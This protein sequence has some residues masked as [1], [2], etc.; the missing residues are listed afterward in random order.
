VSA[1]T[2]ISA[3]IAQVNDI[4]N[5]IA[6]AV[7]ER[8]AT[9]GEMIRNIAEAAKSSSEIAQNITVVAEAARGTSGGAT[10]T[11]SASIDLSRMASELH[12]LV[13]TFKYQDDASE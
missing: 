8:T 12:R 3:V 1:I 9:T 10:Q 2:Q 13:G 7:E 5:T 11:R 6:P 4:S